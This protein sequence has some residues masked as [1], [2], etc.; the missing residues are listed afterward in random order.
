MLTCSEAKTA[1]RER[2]VSD[3]VDRGQGLSSLQNCPGTGACQ[4]S[5]GKADRN[6]DQGHFTL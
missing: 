1:S 3:G 6:R 5:C 4:V 2:G